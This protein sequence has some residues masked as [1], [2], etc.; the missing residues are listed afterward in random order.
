MPCAARPR[1]TIATDPNA[2]YRLRYSRAM[3]AR[4]NVPARPASSLALVWY[5]IALVAVMASA[6]LIGSTEVDWRAFLAGDRTARAIV[7]DLRAPRVLLAALTGAGLSVAGAMMQA[8]FRNPLADPALIGVSSGAALGAILAIVLGLGGLESQSLLGLPALPLAA[9]AGALATTGLLFAFARSD[10]VAGL[11][12]A[13]V[14]FNSL[15]GAAIG[16]LTWLAD[17]GHLRNLTFWLLGSF[18]GA[19]W[20]LIAAVAPLLSLPVLVAPRLARALN[21]LLLGEIEAGYLGF[22]VSRLKLVLVLL[23]ALAV[24][25]AVAAAG[26]IGFV[27]LVMPHIARRVSGPDH[28]IVLPASALLGAT[29]STAADLAARTWVA[30]AELPVGV[31]LAAFG[32]PAFLWLL[33]RQEQR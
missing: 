23:T 12:L 28:R 7:L 4:V 6:L 19:N 24:G 1:K 32:A 30:P 8:M 11:L 29:L 13:G 20:P 17:D 22:S 33:K 26:V 31:L 25:A 16:A 9:F 21:A 14:A 27:G 10:T 2:R 3:F 5:A 18:G 15:A